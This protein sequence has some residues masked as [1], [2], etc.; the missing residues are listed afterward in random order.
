MF[1]RG[2]L[3]A[4]GI[5]LLSGCSSL[6]GIFSSSDQH[7]AYAPAELPVLTAV[8]YA[9]ILEQP[10]PSKTQKMLQAIRASK[11]D[12]YRELSEQVYG[13]RVHGQTRLGNVVQKDSQ[14]QAS[15]DGLV[16]GARVVQSYALDNVYVTR[17]ELDMKLVH[18]LTQGAFGGRSSQGA[19]T[20]RF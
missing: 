15:V 18:Q 7:K 14:L 13:Q 3:V 9:P 2:W 10:G 4:G 6:S 12:A 16:R 1:Y 5:L 11:L 19:A 8:G 20:R 17:L